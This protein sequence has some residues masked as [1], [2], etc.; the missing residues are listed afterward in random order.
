MLRIQLFGRFEALTADGPARGLA[1]RKVQELLSCLLLERPRPAQRDQFADR[2]W[3]DGGSAHSRK[4]LR[5]ALWRLQAALAANGCGR[6]LR[7]DAEWIEID[8]EAGLWVD[9]LELRRTY[10]RRCAAVEGRPQPGG[11]EA[12]MRA[13]DLYTAPLLEGWY[14]DWCLAA[15][16]EHRAM[17]LAL[18]DRLLA[19]AEATGQWEMGLSRGRRALAEEPASE[20]VHRRLMRL[21]HLGG[22]R[23]AA[24]RQFLL[25]TA[26]LERELRVRP[27][28]ETVRL[29]EQIRDGLP[30]ADDPGGAE[31]AARRRVSIAV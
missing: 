23:T 2:L 1:S 7:T 8:D 21:H 14:D 16:D 22:D 20:R 30:L 4:Y 29:Y 5:Q 25:C 28:Q 26:A 6:L 24:L 31:T 11:D 15:R 13:V 17:Y 18:V 10:E 12:L 27:A 9:A 3:G 19:R